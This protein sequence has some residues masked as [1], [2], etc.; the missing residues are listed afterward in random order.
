MRRCCSRC[1][2]SLLRCSPGRP[3]PRQGFRFP[4]P[5]RRGLLPRPTRS[6]SPRGLP[7]PRRFLR[8]YC[9]RSTPSLRPRGTLCHTRLK[10]APTLQEY[11]RWT[12]SWQSRESMLLNVRTQSRATARPWAQPDATA[13]TRRFLAAAVLKR[14]WTRAWVRLRPQRSSCCRRL[15]FFGGRRRSAVGSVEKLL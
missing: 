4:R 10:E 1:F 3:W 15:H 9:C 14:N 13:W 2:E 7:T 8:R 11:A 12:G 5:S 6:P